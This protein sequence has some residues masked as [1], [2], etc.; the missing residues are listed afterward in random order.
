[1]H[2]TRL[3]WRRFN[4]SAALARAISQVSAVPVEERLL[5]RVNAT[6]PQVGKSRA[7]RAWNVQ[8]AFMVPRKLRA[9]V[10]GRRFVL[11]DDVIASGSTVDAC[12]RALRRAGARQVDVLAF[13]RVVEAW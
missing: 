1:L 10:K 12:A 8:G 3:W 13:A 5:A 11:V 7:E 4:Q 6:P 2:W 9:A